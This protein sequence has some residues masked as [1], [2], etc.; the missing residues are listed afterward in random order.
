MIRNK[1]QG[2]QAK[3]LLFLGGFKQVR[4]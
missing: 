4:V 1:N 2:V 3:I